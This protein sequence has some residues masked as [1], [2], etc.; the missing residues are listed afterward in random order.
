MTL[1]E[2]VESLVIISVTFVNDR[3]NINQMKKLV[4]I[5]YQGKDNVGTITAQLLISGILTGTTMFS[6]T[7]EYEYGAGVC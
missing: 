1:G 7:H 6:M 4:I 2:F 5:R 3:S